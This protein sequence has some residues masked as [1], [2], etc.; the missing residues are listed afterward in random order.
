MKFFKT[1]FALS[2][3]LLQTQYFVYCNTD[4]IVGFWVTENKFNLLYFNNNI[5]IDNTRS[6][7]CVSI[8]REKT[9][10]LYWV[11]S[12]INIANVH[13]TEKYII[14]KTKQNHL[15]IYFNDNE[16]PWEFIPMEFNSCEN[17]IKSLTLTYVENYYPI[18]RSKIDID[19]TNNAVYKNGIKQ[20][21]TGTMSWIKSY[22][23]DLIVE[24]R[25]DIDYPV[26]PPGV[27]PIDLTLYYENNLTKEFR[28]WG[29][30]GAPLSVQALLM[31]VVALPYTNF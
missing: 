14:E 30:L 20:T 6:L 28:F 15:L 23:F 4:T 9:D 19:L 21:I 12:C 25:D 17:S 1:I 5:I 22:C 24:L 18:S 13:P 29:T 2:L 7:S 16:K 3:F 31:Y 27:Q 10:F 26:A 8:L 11:D